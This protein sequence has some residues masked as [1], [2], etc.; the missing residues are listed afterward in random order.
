MFNN[1]TNAIATESPAL[2]ANTLQQYIEHQPS[3]L[4][5][6]E[7]QHNW[8]LS[9]QPLSHFKTWPHHYKETKKHEQSL[10][11]PTA[12]KPTPSKTYANLEVPPN[13]Q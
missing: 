4:G 1:T 3:I 8:K 9:E 13:S 12:K 5:L 10:P 7:M 2:L 6:M 11:Q